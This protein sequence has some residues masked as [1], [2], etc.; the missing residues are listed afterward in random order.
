MKINLDGKLST[1]TFAL[2]IKK[3][4]FFK[5]KKIEKRKKNLDDIITAP[6]FALPMKKGNKVK[7]KDL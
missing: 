6:T 5:G 1:F 3:G 4:A 2:P 7:P